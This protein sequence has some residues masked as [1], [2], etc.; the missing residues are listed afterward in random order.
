M[1]VSSSRE[2][3]I[4]VSCLVCWI[5]GGGAR[6]WWRRIVAGSCCRARAMNDGNRQ[7]KQDDNSDEDGNHEPAGVHAFIRVGPYVIDRVLCVVGHGCEMC[8]RQSMSSIKR[9]LIRVTKFR[10]AI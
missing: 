3:Y 9:R 2:A 7:Q 10:A 4:H 5:R 1:L 8:L 6:G